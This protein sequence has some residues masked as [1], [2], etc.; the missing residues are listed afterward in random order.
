MSSL[1]PV[2]R[3]MAEI[4]ETRYPDIDPW[5]VLSVATT[6]VQARDGPD[7]RLDTVWRLVLDDPGTVRRLTHSSMPGGMPYVDCH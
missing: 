5:R 1:G 2:I 4:V 3:R 6:Y 7:A